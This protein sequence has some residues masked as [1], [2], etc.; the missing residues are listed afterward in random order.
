[1]KQLTDFSLKPPPTP[2]PLPATL[3]D[4]SVKDQEAAA[5]LDWRAERS[6]TA[7]DRSEDRRMFMSREE[8]VP[9]DK[10]LNNSMGES[11]LS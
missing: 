3:T 11:I 2:A 1:M 5:A 7:C 6:R 10:T 9:T 8:R 4:A